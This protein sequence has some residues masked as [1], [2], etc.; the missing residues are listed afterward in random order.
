[1]MAT[2]CKTKGPRPLWTTYFMGRKHQ[3]IRAQGGKVTGRLARRLDAVADQGSASGVNPGRGL[4]DRLDDACLVIGRLK[5][6]QH[7]APG[8]SG[9]SCV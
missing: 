6:Q 1:M 2:L 3:N 4:G 5:R 9:Q 8:V 7:P